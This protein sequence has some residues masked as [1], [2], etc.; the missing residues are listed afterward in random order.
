[1]PKG[2][3][4]KFKIPELKSFNFQIKYNEIEPK[5][6]WHEIDLHIHNEFELYINLE[7]DISFLVGDSLYPVSRGDVIIARPGEQHHCVYRSDKPHKMFWILFDCQKNSSL[8]DFLQPE[9]ND[10]YIP[11]EGKLSEEIL[12]LC[13]KLHSEKLSKEEQLYSFFRIFAILKESK[14]KSANVEDIL[15]QDLSQIIDYIDQHIHEQLTVTQIANDLF[16]SQ[17]T[18]E[19]RFKQI[20]DITPLEFIRK[21]KLILAAQLL[22]SGESVL[23]TGLNLGYS[24][25][26]YFI[27][28][29]KKY[30]GCTPYKYKLINKKA[31]L[32]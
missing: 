23:Q 24:D 5:N 9:F 1:M 12:E 8:L 11:T 18:L 20:L 4:T 6:H 30:Y 7:G 28:I 29:F 3:I 27:Q 25:N 16:I 15:P 2:T 31:N 32:P 10:N 13:A 19:R 21:K 22:Q 17:S 26:S 14:N